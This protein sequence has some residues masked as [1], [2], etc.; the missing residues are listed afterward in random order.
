M[1]RLV[2][3]AAAVLLAAVVLVVMVP[4][5]STTTYTLLRG[6][7]S[8]ALGLGWLYWLCWNIIATICTYVVFPWLLLPGVLVDIPLQLILWRFQ[9]IEEHLMLSYFPLGS[10]ASP[11]HPKSTYHPGCF[12]RAGAT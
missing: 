8:A 5:A 9:T 1:M 12:A 3:P 2:A 6:W 10:G 7:L 4:G 11:R